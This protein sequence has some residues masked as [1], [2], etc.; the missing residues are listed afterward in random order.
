M[1]PRDRQDLKVVLN[2]AYPVRCPRW[3]WGLEEG[4]HQLQ[5]FLVL[6]NRKPDWSY[7]TP[8]GPLF[9]ISWPGTPKSCRWFFIHCNIDLYPW[10]HFPNNCW[11]LERASPTAHQQAAV[12]SGTNLRSEV[13]SWGSAQSRWKDRGMAWMSGRWAILEKAGQLCTSQSW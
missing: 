5:L 11:S 10:P 1:T 2:S 12:L 8:G 6:S 4:L 3:D 13:P 7:E 9:P